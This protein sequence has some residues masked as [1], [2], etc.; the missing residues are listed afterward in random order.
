M[1]VIEYAHHAAV[2]RVH[3][4]RVS[5]DISYDNVKAPEPAD[6]LAKMVSDQDTAAALD[7]FEPQMPQYKAL[8]EKLA[9]LRAGKSDPSKPQ[10]TEGPAPKIGQPDDRVA[11]LRDRLGVSGDG[12]VYDKPLAEAVKKFQQQHDLK[13]TGTL[14]PQT[15]QAL[16]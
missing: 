12:N 1:A 6:V 8:K 15:I 3:W 9:E 16:N 11:E 5:P 4:S 14:T 10:I 2:G 13:A 7:S